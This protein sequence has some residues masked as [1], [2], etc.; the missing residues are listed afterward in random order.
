MNNCNRFR[1]A[2]HFGVAFMVVCIVGAVAS[3]RSPWGI[4]LT[5][6][7]LGVLVGAW[8]L[9]LKEKGRCLS[10]WKWNGAELIGLVGLGAGA[11]VV[12]GIMVL[13]SGQHGADG[14]G[15][16]QTRVLAV[17]TLVLAITAGFVVW[18]AMAA[19]RQAEIL[20]DQFDVRYRPHLRPEVFCQT[21]SHVGIRLINLAGAEAIEPGVYPEWMTEHKRNGVLELKPPT[22]PDPPPEEGFATCSVLA[23]SKAGHWWVRR[24]K[25]GE[26]WE[27][28]VR[29]GQHPWEDRLED[30]WRLAYVDPCKKGKLHFEPPAEVT[31]RGCG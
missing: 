16:A 9:F 12:G 10:P 31:R 18:Y 25:A 20:K 1:M 28:K 13:C 14:V 21:T 4:L 8:V 15:A 6:V 3:G 23:V 24:P 7:G 17:Q 5:L 22:L 2:V 29:W 11:L 26:S 30:I 19:H 27:V